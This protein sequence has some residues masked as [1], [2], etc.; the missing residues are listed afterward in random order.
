MSDSTVKVT[1]TGDTSGLTAAMGQASVSAAD[2]AKAIQ[3]AGGDL[4]K[5]TPAM[6][7]LSPPTQQAAAAMNS[8]STAATGLMQRMQALGQASLTAA[9]GTRTASTAATSLME[10]MRDQ[11]Q[12]TM[13][14]SSKLEGATGSMNTFTGG[15]TRARTEIVVLAHEM[16][17]GRFSRIPGSLMVLAESMGGVSL[18][19]MGVGAAV[20]AVGVGL[21]EMVEHAKAAAAALRAVQAAYISIGRGSAFDAGGVQ[22]TAKGMQQDY[23]TSSK[24]AMAVLA[25]VQA[26]P[27]ASDAARDSLARLA[28][29]IAD[30]NKS[31]DSDKD[32]DL[33]A[34]QADTLARGAE[35][36][37]AMLALGRTFNL[38]SA[39]QIK[40]ITAA[41]SLL[42]AQDIYVQALNAR[43]GDQIK[44]LKERQ[45]FEH[46]SPSA[47]NRSAAGK[48]PFDVYAP[49]GMPTAPVRPPGG[50]APDAGALDLL[51]AEKPY[52]AALRERQTLEANIA[53]MHK[54]LAG[55]MSAADRQETESALKVAQAKMAQLKA[56]GDTG[57]LQKQEVALADQNAG[58]TASAKTTEQA[59]EMRLSSTVK[60]WAQI[61]QGQNLTD[62]QRSQAELKMSAAQQQLDMAHLRATITTGKQGTEARVAELSAQQ[63]ANRD[64]F[65]QWQALEQQKLGILKAAYGEQSRQ[66]QAELRNMENYQRQHLATLERQTLE[67]LSKENQAGQQAIASKRAEL[68]QELADHQITK[69]DE[70]AELK[71]YSDQ[72]YKIEI[73]N[74]DT[75][76]ATLTRGTQEYQRAM[77]Q[78]NALALKAAAVDKQL[79]ADIVRAQ[80]QAAERSSQYYLRSF[81]EIGSSFNSTVSGL[82]KGT[83]TWQQAELRVASSIVDSVINLGEKVLA[84]WLATEIGKT[85]MTSQQTAIR[86]SI[87]AG[88]SGFDV[89]G[90]ALLEWVG[91]EQS[92]TT[93]S[94]A[95]TAAREAVD[96]QAASTAAVTQ[97]TSS[98]AQISAAAGVA[99]ANAFAAT[100]AIPIVGPELAP[101]AAATAYAEVMAFSASAIP[102]F[103]VGSWSVPSDMLAM[104]HQGEMIIPAAQAAQVRTGGGSPGAGFPGVGGGMGGIVFNVQAIDAAG[105]QAF[106]NAHGDKIAR[107]VTRHMTANPSLR[108]RY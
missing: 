52:L 18:A 86:A 102:G 4:T 74:L 101:A 25:R 99:A 45:Q 69:E 29:A 7:G 66:Y 36:K 93:A 92:K 77:D 26:I 96:V 16:L 98:M 13:D 51:D 41:N 23:G 95:G 24:D 87:E 19:T 20:A 47:V 67:H 8:A 48:H 78:R 71:N 22:A 75:F 108:P 94:V 89:I 46:P 80:Q 10:K 72:Q 70:L 27:Q 38:F 14:A 97:A 43:Y 63:A 81:N 105:V 103:A 2:F 79:A 30:L 84:R 57:W 107:T 88:G 62:A 100:A 1:I 21:Y 49:A 56:A 5:I 60:F 65:T 40:G 12:A 85:L 104:I 76:I 83:T 34:K 50:S 42:G 82:V 37:E 54:A 44:F 53:T 61:L 106:F 91:L 17:T 33:A 59:N 15:T 90:R 68:D 6:V 64:N 11:A 55:E 32:K 31:G 58:I 39:D 35:S 73:G 28:L 9:A 3:A